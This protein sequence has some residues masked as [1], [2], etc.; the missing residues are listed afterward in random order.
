MR[1]VDAAWPAPRATLHHSVRT[2]PFLL[3][4][5]TSMQEWQPHR[6]AVMQARGWP[7]GEARV[8][9]EVEATHN[10]C[11]VSIH[12]MPVRGPGR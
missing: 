9:I 4:G 6:R 11:L 10:G 12:E 5:T 2:W 3:N 7:I 8:T 1:E